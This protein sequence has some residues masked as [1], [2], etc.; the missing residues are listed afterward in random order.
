MLEGELKRVYMG[1]KTGTGPTSPVRP[2]S[3]KQLERSF[4][5]PLEW[6]KKLFPSQAKM[7]GAYPTLSPQTGSG[8]LAEIDCSKKS[9][10]SRK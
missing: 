5:V 9:S 3:Q 8:Q 7:D 6:K 1:R 10:G 4:C 2:D